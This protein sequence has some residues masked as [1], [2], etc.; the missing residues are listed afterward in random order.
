MTVPASERYQKATG[1]TD[2]LARSVA[3]HWTTNRMKKMNCPKSPMRIHR[4][5]PVN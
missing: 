3:I 4:S 1:T 5:P 2:R